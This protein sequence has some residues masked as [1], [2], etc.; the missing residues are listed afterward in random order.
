T[1][2]FAGELFGKGQ[3]LDAGRYFIIIPDGIGHGQSSKPSDGLRTRF[4]RYGYTDMV[5]AQHRLLT[6]ALKVDHL[7]LG[8]GTSMGGMHTWLW[9]E[10]YPDFMDALVPLACLPTQISGRNR[11]WRTMGVEAIRTHPD[12][13][14]GEYT[15]QPRGVRITAQLLML[16][17]S[18]PT[19]RQKQG[20]T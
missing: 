6:D 9:G 12:W 4:P 16:M 18:N 19:N 11:L 14:G 5:A 7:R 1:H 8:V 20:P 2:P 17:G 10:K 3:P 13:K 15:T